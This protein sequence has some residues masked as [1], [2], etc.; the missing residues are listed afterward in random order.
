MN[1]LSTTLSPPKVLSLPLNLAFDVRTKN[2]DVRPR[3]SLAPD[4]AKTKNQLCP[5]TT[6]T[7]ATS[8]QRKQKDTCV[9][10]KASQAGLE[11]AAFGFR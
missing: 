11:P 6:S 4:C 9:K 1:A 7:S 2:V 8:N 5:P 10:Q 3:P